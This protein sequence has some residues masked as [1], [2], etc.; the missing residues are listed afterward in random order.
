ML[1]IDPEEENH[2]RLLYQS[3]ESAGGNPNER[4]SEFDD[5]SPRHLESQTLLDLRQRHSGTALNTWSNNYGTD[6]VGE[7]Q[8]LEVIQESSGIIAPVISIPVTI[9]NDITS[10]ESFTSVNSSAVHKKSKAEAYSSN[11]AVVSLQGKLQAGKHNYQGDILESAASQSWSDFE[12]LFPMNYIHFLFESHRFSSCLEMSSATTSSNESAALVP[13]IRLNKSSSSNGRQGEY[14]D[15]LVLRLTL[16]NS[17]CSSRRRK[18]SNVV[19]N[20]RKRA[21]Q[22]DENVNPLTGAEE[23]RTTIP[24]TNA[25]GKTTF[26]SSICAAPPAID[27]AKRRRMQRDAERHRE[28][29]RHE[30]EEQRKQRQERDAARHRAAYS[31]KKMQKL[32]SAGNPSNYHP[33]ADMSFSSPITT[34]ITTSITSSIAD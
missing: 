19:A 22:V 14:S 26:S 11:R 33:E 24:N 17:G 15:D 8:F 12:G 6:L 31:R 5:L 10:N 9:L 20:A 13:T 21:L 32:A 23:V 34:S 27:E 7:G 30:T 3:T 16:S 2:Q 25:K 28:Y 18:G 1:E 29:Y 4:W